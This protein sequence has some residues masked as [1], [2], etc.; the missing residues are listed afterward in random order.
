MGWFINSVKYILLIYNFLNKTKFNINLAF[1][2]KIHGHKL[3]ILI[4]SHIATF[5][6]YFI[7]LSGEIVKPGLILRMWN[8]KKETHL[9]EVSELG[10]KW[11]NPQHC[12]VLF[13][14]SCSRC[15]FCPP[16]RVE[17]MFLLPLKAWAERGLLSERENIQLDLR[18][19]ALTPTLALDCSP[20]TLR[21]TRQR[22]GSWVQPVAQVGVFSNVFF[23]LAVRAD[24]KGETHFMI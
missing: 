21:L 23:F 11:I 19:M 14:P 20:A 2:I 12:S 16:S 17:D 15:W 18:G 6:N 24:T 1:K 9:T 8:C 7:N 10:V 13:P 3:L 5:S 4:K 22:K